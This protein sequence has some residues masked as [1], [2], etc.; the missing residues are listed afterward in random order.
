MISILITFVILIILDILWF[1]ISVPSIYG[2]LFK[3]INGQSGYMFLP[4]AIL[5]WLLIAI[6]ISFAQSGQE[7][8]LLGFLS[9]GIYNATNY[10]TIKNWTLRTVFFDTLW[11]SVVC[12]SA[13][14]LVQML[15]V[16]FKG[17]N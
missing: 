5:S 12:F 2:P 16:R 13:Y 15:K 6:L 14:S 17:L 1:Q 3:S 7:A 4:S 9:Y 8:A 11:G 10:A